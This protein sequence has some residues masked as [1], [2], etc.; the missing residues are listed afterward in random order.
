[1]AQGKR[2]RPGLNPT[3]VGFDPSTPTELVIGLVGA[4]GTDWDRIVQLLTERLERYGYKHTTIRMTKDVMPRLA[5]LPKAKP[6]FEH[7]RSLID[8]GNAIRKA[9]HNN[10]VLGWAA[11]ASI[12][13]T[14]PNKKGVTTKHAYIVRSLKHYEEVAAL[15]TIYAR[16]FYLFAVH[17]PRERRLELLRES[18]DGMTAAEA[19]ELIDRDENEEIKYGQHTRDT[20]HLAD[21]FLADESNDDKLRHSIWRCLDLM[22]SSPLVTPTFNEFAM[23][24]AFASSLRSGDLA[25]QVGAVV[26][27]ETEILS[28]GANDAPRSGGGLYWPVFLEN[29]IADVPNGRDLVRGFDSNTKEKRL[30]AESIADVLDVSKGRARRVMEG[31]RLADVTEYGRSVHAE[32][33]ALL[34]CARSAQTVR[35]GT[36]YCTT[37]PCHNCAKHIVASGLREVVFVEPYPKSRALEFHDDSITLDPTSREKVRFKPFIGV[38]PRQFLNL[39]SM[40]M[41]PGHEL[42]RKSRDGSVA[43]WSETDAHPRVQMSP[44]SYREMET[45]IAL[46]YMARLSRLWGPRPRNRRRRRR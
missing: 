10:G 7:A 5:R 30:I 16:G 15:R 21:F 20:F 18:G 14:R 32:M 19:E 22:F 12:A 34:A 38:G 42:V 23:F 28:T 40:T 6:K 33:E 11:A 29:R 46:P 3:K 44:I 17:T 41:G 36:L 25:R 37:F 31:S 24:M 9:S 8:L 27:R 45:Q 4:L 39:F 43:K 35:G 1:M 13:E 26:S 2:R